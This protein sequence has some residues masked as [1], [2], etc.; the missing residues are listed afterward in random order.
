MIRNLVANSS[1]QKTNWRCLY[2]IYYIG[3]DI[4]KY[5]HDFCIISNAGEAIVENDSFDNT[6]NGFQYFVNLLKSYDK[7]KVRIAFEAT[8]HYLRIWNFS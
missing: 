8:G 2:M 6:K 1:V 4:S 3:I 5:K 7:S